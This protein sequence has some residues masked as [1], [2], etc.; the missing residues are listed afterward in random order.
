MSSA[1][2]HRHRAAEQQTQNRKRFSD[3]AMGAFRRDRTPS[4]A[5]S[6]SEGTYITG[7]TIL[8]YVRRIAWDSSFTPQ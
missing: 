5:L 3:S 2:L 4:P 1:D 8:R 6:V 7:Q